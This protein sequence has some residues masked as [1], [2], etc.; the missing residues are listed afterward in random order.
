VDP[1]YPQARD[2][3]ESGGHDVLLLGNLRRKVGGE[4]REIRYAGYADRYDGRYRTGTQDGGNNQCQQKARKSYHSVDNPK[5][6]F[7]GME[8]WTALAIESGVSPDRAA[9]FR[10]NGTALVVEVK[11]NRPGPSWGL[12]VDIDALPMHESAESG[13]FP[14]N[15]GFNSTV[16]AMHACGHDLHAT[17]GVGLLHRLADRDFGGT[18]RVFFQPAEEGVRGAQTMIDAASPGPHHSAKF[19]A[20]EEAIP[21]G[22]DILEALIRKHPM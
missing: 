18:L 12:R 19:D 3:Q 11:G 17:I 1:G 6:D 2:P 15:E 16:A 13:H 21:L 5:R 9:Y 7:T 8:A 4:P 22:I 10:D 20:D 14:A